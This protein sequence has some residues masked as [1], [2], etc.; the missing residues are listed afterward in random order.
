MKGEIWELSKEERLRK[1]LAELGSLLPCKIEYPPREPPFGCYSPSYEST[2]SW[3]DVDKKFYLPLEAT[4][5]LLEYNK[6]RIIYAALAWDLHYSALD[7][8]LKLVLNDGE[9][10]MIGLNSYLQ[11]KE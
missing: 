9:V 7:C 8:Y 4:K 5:K 11:G 1:I 3:N 6:D 2:F 10:W